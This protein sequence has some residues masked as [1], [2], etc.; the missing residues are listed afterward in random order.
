MNKL[1]ISVG[2]K[3][4]IANIFLIVIFV[5]NISL[6]SYQLNDNSILI[7]KNIN[8]MTPSIAVLE[9]FNHII[10]KSKLYTTNWVYHK[11]NKESKELLRKLH[12]YDFLT[13]KNKITKLKNS[14]KYK[15]DIIEI[16]SILVSF[17]ENVLAPQKQIMS[18]QLGSASVVHRSLNIEKSYEQKIK[19]YSE[20]LATRLNKLIVKKRDEFDSNNRRIINS[21]ENVKNSSIVLAIFLLLIM[22]IKVIIMR[23]IISKPIK[24][25]SSLI[26]KLS[27]GEIPDLTENKP[28]I[29]NDEIGDIA[30]SIDDL[31]NGLQSTIA[32]AR[33]IGS[34]QYK[35][36]YTAISSDDILANTLISMRQNLITIAEE[37]KTQNWSS[38]GIAMF[39]E[40]LRKNHD[41]LHL[42]Y[43]NILFN[44]VKYLDANQGGVFII[45][46]EAEIPYMKLESCYAWDKK[47]FQEKVIQKGEGLAG[48]SWLEQ[49]TIYL[50]DI[51]EKHIKITS[52]LGEKKPNCILI[53]PILFNDVI[54]G[55]IELASFHKFK[56]HEIRF[57][58]Q[59]AE[60]FASTLTTVKINQRTKFLLEK[61][62]L[63]TKQ[64]RTQ[65]AELR[66][67]MEELQAT[68]EDIKRSQQK[69][70]LKDKETERL[71]KETKGQKDKLIQQEDKMKQQMKE[72]KVTQKVMK[73]TQR[74]LSEYKSN[75]DGLINNTEDSIFAIDNNYQ[76]TVINKTLVERFSYDGLAV[77]I[78][79]NILDILPRQKQDFWKEKYD[80]TF[81][82]E[83]FSFQQKQNVK[84]KTLNIQVSL[85]PIYDSEHLIVGAFIISK[86]ITAIKNQETKI[87]YLL[88]KTT[89]DAKEIN[90]QKDFYDSILAFVNGAMYR[91]I[92]TNEQRWEFQYINKGIYE[93]TGYHE[94]EFVNST[95]S[96]SDIIH[97]EDKLITDEEIEN[98]ES[99]F[100]VTY[101]II[102]KN[103][104]IRWVQEKGMKI[105]DRKSGELL[106]IGFIYD[107]SEEKKQEKRIQ[108]YQERLEKQN[109]KL[110]IKEAK[111]NAILNTGVSIIAIDTEYKVILINDSY[112][113]R[114][115]G[116]AYEG[117]NEGTDVLGMLGDV[118]EEWKGYYDRGFNGESFGFTIKNSLTD[119]DSYRYYYINPIK[120]KKKIIGIS[121][122]S[123]DV[124][125]EEVQ[126]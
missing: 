9:D 71:L 2:Q 99:E 43:Y 33:S 75:L 90:H 84:N 86:D 92:A 31:V 50:T 51:P 28:K 117:I 40:I 76:I 12:A 58:E 63:L 123:T 122:F 89:K 119:K 29:T 70:I 55:V 35:Y 46:D 124:T 57:V 41:D 34:G 4:L 126:K 54:H 67:N 73:N 8:V 115:A 87:Q 121:I 88:E 60:L 10:T 26:K 105:H 94:S 24:Y 19:P 98:S 61:S 96:F 120:N 14:W 108:N 5:A 72:L 81:G 7:Y 44:M 114:Y 47:K 69:L 109:Q 113:K 13:A 25:L 79:D 125:S 53:T 112:K 59:V 110:V 91:C 48:Q 80:R 65:K 78:G 23:N 39:A 93:L 49:E 102:T 27:K 83:V 18:L 100:V 103:S 36:E 30:N 97:P 68:Q 106:A 22:I 77:G 116:T 56:K 20:L 64:L 85:N 1:R 107:V 74:N 111:L 62:T 101:R 37:S 21:S 66:H 6:V 32:F 52:G 95:I 3:I 82:G 42:F 104:I 118:L 16:N 15:E 17:Y 38:N 45:E 11:N